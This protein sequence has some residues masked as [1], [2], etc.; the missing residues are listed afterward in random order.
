M[1]PEESTWIWIKKPAGGSSGAG[2]KGQLESCRAHQGLLCKNAEVKKMTYDSLV[3]FSP[4]LGE[5]A[6]ES[7]FN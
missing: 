5:L 3:T 1:K 6:I 7:L 4:F 2:H